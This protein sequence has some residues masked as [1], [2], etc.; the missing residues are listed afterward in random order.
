MG[1]QGCGIF[2]FDR[3]ICLLSHKGSDMQEKLNILSDKSHQAKN[4]N[5][6]NQINVYFYYECSRSHRIERQTS[7]QSEVV[8]MFGQ[9]DVMTEENDVL[10]N[11]NARVTKARIAIIRLNKVFRL[12]ST[13]V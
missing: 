3:R 12:N 2:G 9:S 8:Y 1:F 11:K 5:E 4:Q 7:W 10:K 6:D 13:T